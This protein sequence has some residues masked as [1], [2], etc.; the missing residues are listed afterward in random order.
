MD[1]SLNYDELTDH[2]RQFLPLDK[3]WIIIAES[4]SGPIGLKIASSHPKGLQGLILCATFIKNPLPRCL[5]PIR[6][7]IKPVLFKLKLPDFLMRHFLLGKDASKE[8]L[9]RFRDTLTKIGAKVLADRVQAIFKV[10]MTRELILYD[11]PVLYLRATE[12]HLVTKKS[13]K[14]IQGIK[15]G[16][17]VVSIRSPHLLFQTAPK[18]GAATI[19]SF[20]IT[21]L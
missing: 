9:G 20:L 17:K 11:G 8:S 16:I 15:P 18:D 2:V 12:D 10:D 6:F 1:Q 13:L 5:Y 4:F 21:A 14:M 3:P 7:L 19:R